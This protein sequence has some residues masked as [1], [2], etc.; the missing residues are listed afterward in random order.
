MKL[1]SEDFLEGETF[2][3]VELRGV[4][5]AH[6]ELYRCTF[7]G[8][9]L[10][11]AKL[12]RVVFEQCVFE[13]VDLSGVTWPHSALRDVRFVRCKLMGVHFGALSPNP[14]VSFEGCDLRYCVFDGVHLR[15]TRFVDCKLQDAS[16]NACNLVD[17]DFSGSELGG[18]VFGRC[19]LAGADLS[20]CSGLFLDPASNKVKGA[21]VPVEAAVEL[22]R[23]Q[24]LKVAGYDA[25]KK[26][27]RR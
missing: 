9:A 19:E 24:G 2:T 22:A 1:Q 6:K 3:A 11:T 21:F 16:F 14:E 26:K 13:D 20:T 27:S 23:V 7:R 8:G 15:D 17:A 4:T 5:L 18:A 10:A 12:E 25:P